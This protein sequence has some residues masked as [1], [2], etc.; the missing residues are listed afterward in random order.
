MELSIGHT[1]YRLVAT[2]RNGQWTTH[3]V[4]TDSGERFGIEATAP[5]EPEAANR[6]TRWLEWQF[7]HTQALGA[8]QQAERAYHRAMADAA[9][10]VSADSVASGSR[11]SLELV[12][13]ARMQLD[14]VRAQRPNV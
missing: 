14:D 5:S 7:E 1:A 11:T 2:E 4:R 8:L 6:L 12:D 10:S 13:A 9:F 3:A